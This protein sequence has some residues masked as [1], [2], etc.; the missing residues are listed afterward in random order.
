MQELTYLDLGDPR[1]ARRLARLLSDLGERPGVGIP[2]ACGTAAATKAAY[3]FL[4]NDAVAADA[5]RDAHVAATRERVRGLPLLLA[6][7]DTTTLDF[8]SPAVAGAVRVHSVL[9]VHP[10]GAPLGLLAQQVWQRDPE[11]TG[12]RHTRRQRPTVEK[13]S[14]RWLDAERATLQALPA[15]APVLTIADQEADIFD[16]FAQARPPT[17][18]LLIRVTHPRRIAEAPGQIWAALAA[19][20]VGDVVPIA[21]GRRA[22]RAPRE[23]LLTLRWREVTVRPPRNRPDQAQLSPVTLTALVAEEPVPPPGQRAIC[24][25]LLTTLP[26]PDGEAALQ[27]VRWYALRWQI[28][29]YHYVLKS[30][31][32]IEAL[33]LRQVARLERALAVFAIVAWRLL[34]L[35]ALSRTDPEAPCTVALS[36]QE[37]P[38]LWVAIHQRADVPAHPP[39]LGEAMRWVAQLGGYL[40]RA[41]DDPPG[42]K[43]LWRGLRRL[44]D[45]TA[46]WLLARAFP[47]TSIA[48]LVGNG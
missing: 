12:K 16:L 38:V 11:T 14:Q 37:W 30:G 1:R 23:A 10:D 6:V 48:T 3:R 40:N 42:V 5:I 47:T 19:T 43:V 13:E 9:A 41:S 15:G 21:V 46:G 45:L 29:R 28:E 32:Q 22:D 31:C 20:P 39:P 8:P 33:Q 25:R 44:E 24:W 27:C 4:D 35:M 34:W 18:E 36:A 26:I 7:Q 2:T 17:A